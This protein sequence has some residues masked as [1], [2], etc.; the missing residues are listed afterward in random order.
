[1]KKF[2]TFFILI[3]S[4]AAVSAQD[5]GSRAPDFTLQDMDGKTFKSSD[6]FGK[7]PLLIDF[8]ATWCNPCKVELPHLDAIFKKYEKQGL[9]FLAIS[10]DSPRSLS[11]VKPYVKSKNFAAKVLLD[12]DGQVLKKF[13]GEGTLPYTI[14][15][16][17]EG[18]IVRTFTG[19]VPGQEADIEKMVADMLSQAAEPTP[20]S[21][22]R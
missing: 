5:V 19:Y 3:L 13:F 2:A 18:K 6:Y 4:A 22:S 17:R 8:W 10:E 12:P 16:N 21:Q 14:L 20:E 1:M 9:I 15:I 7:Q 11:K